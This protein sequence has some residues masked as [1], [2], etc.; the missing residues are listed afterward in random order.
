M[1]SALDDSHRALQPTPGGKTAGWLV[2]HLAITGDFGRRLCG[3][4]PICPVEWR[5][6]FNPG[7]QPSTNPTDYPPM[8]DLLAHFRS[9][10]EDLQEALPAASAEALGAV[11]PFE[12]GRASFPTV[13]VFVAWMMGGHLGYHLGQLHGWR[14]AAGIR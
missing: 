14:A 11:N 7:T 12:P 13:G 9:V 6:K 10:Y 2:G 4:K 1:L 3:R 8:A 5:A